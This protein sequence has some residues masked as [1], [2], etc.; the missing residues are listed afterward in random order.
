MDKKQKLRDYPVPSSPEDIKALQ[1]AIE[2][3][4]NSLIRQDAEKQLR[5]DIYTTLA[6]KVE[7][8]KDIFNKMVQVYY[9][10]SFDAEVSAAED[11]QEIYEKVMTGKDSS[12][13]TD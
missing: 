3:S 8:P 10:A 13:K 4:S 2:E 9:K 5:K 6:D 12:L 7:I 1:G 11:F